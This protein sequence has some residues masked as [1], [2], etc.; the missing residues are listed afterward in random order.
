[1][2]AT[3]LKL[4]DINLEKK[5]NVTRCHRQYHEIGP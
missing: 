4:C 3:K 1:M 2:D 5:T